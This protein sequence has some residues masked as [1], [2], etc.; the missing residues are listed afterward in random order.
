M[1]LTNNVKR[2]LQVYEGSNLLHEDYFNKM[3]IDEPRDWHVIKIEYIKNILINQKNLIV[4]A[5]DLVVWDSRTFHQNLCCDEDCDEERLV[6]YLCYLPKN[7][8]ENN[9]RQQKLRKKY[10]EMRRTTSHWPYPINVIPCQPNFYNHFNPDFPIFIDYNLLD[11]PYLDDII[12]KI[13]KL[14]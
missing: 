13:E 11:K 8:E 14:L 9:E 1:S 5:G 3:E 6:Q 2:T 7:S 10:F 4:N 12:K